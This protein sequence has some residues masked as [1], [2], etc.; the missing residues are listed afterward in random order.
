MHATY[1]AS[2]GTPTILQT[3]R[4]YGHGYVSTYRPSLKQGLQTEELL[5]WRYHAEGHYIYIS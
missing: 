3:H 4:W 5:N 1:V 2:F